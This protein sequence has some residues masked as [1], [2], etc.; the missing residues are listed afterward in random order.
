MED[1]KDTGNFTRAIELEIIAVH[2]PETDK[3]NEA[4]RELIKIFEGKPGK[5]LEIAESGERFTFETRK[6]ACKELINHYSSKKDFGGLVELSKNPKIPGMMWME[7]LKESELPALEWIKE[8][9]SKSEFWNLLSL[10][11]S[12]NLPLAARDKLDEV[13]KRKAVE[14]ASPMD[15]EAREKFKGA[16]TGVKST[17]RTRKKRAKSTV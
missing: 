2:H 17:G 3:R 15:K 6:A 1:N 9:D 11:R 10:D 4:G 12:K 14:L 7:A 8:C 16:D 13:L 5:L